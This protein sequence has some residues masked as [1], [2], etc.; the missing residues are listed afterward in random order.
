[1]KRG[2]PLKRSAGLAQGKPL[3]RKTPLKAKTE[4][5]RGAGFKTKANPPKRKS[6]QAKTNRGLG[7]LKAQARRRDGGS[8]VVCG[9]QVG[10]GGNV[11]HRRNRGMGGSRAANV[12]S[13][14]LVACGSPNSGCHGALTNRPWEIDAERNGWVLPTNGTAD[15]AAVPVLVAWLGW[16]YPTTD[17]EWQAIDGTQA[18]AS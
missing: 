9:V 6:S 11:H 4:M 2:G 15:P 10:S 12:I 1:M 14:L 3:T 8:C 16:A 5:P 18:V 7:E 13:N 17:G